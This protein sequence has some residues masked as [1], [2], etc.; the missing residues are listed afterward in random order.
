MLRKVQGKEAGQQ[1]VRQCILRV[2][3]VGA[4]IKLPPS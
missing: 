1:D 4:V 3:T 2:K